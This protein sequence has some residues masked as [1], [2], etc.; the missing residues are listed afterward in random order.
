MRLL[1]V[2]DH[3][4]LAEALADG[5]T[6]GGFA[7]DRAADAVAARQHVAATRYDV[8]VLD[9]GLPGTD[10]LSLLREWRRASGPPVL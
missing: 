5:L 7:V 4:A 1:L 8:V 9:I 6:R 2:E 10:G 3:P